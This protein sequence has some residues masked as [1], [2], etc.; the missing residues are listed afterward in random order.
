VAGT[1]AVVGGADLSVT[2]GTLRGE[3]GATPDAIFEEVPKAYDGL[4][5]GTT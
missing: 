2:C 3:K 5:I 4:L 1:R